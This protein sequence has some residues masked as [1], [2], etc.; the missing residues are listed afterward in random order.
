MIGNTQD[1]MVTCRRYQNKEYWSNSQKTSHHLNSNQK[2]GKFTVQYKRESQRAQNYKYRHHL[3]AT[4]ILLIIKTQTWRNFSKLMA[5][6]IPQV[7]LANYNGWLICD[8]RYLLFKNRK[9]T[10]MIVQA[11][12]KQSFYSISNMDM[13]TLLNTQLGQLYNPANVAFPFKI[14]VLSLTIN[15]PPNSFPINNTLGIQLLKAK[16]LLSQLTNQ[17]DSINT[18]ITSNTARINSTYAQNVNICLI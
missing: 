18:Y 9:L 10:N 5:L 1:W 7:N 17:Y 11:I 8:S 15:Y 4:L 16:S 14:S 12:A 3:N 6:A 2:H 13:K